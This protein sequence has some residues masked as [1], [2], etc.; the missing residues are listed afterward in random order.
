M[1]R[2]TARYAVAPARYRLRT[3]LRPVLTS[4]MA[5]AHGC[6][7]LGSDSGSSQSS[8]LS[9][10]P[11]FDLPL[12]D[13]IPFEGP[14]SPEELLS[15]IDLL[16]PE[17]PLSLKDPF[18]LEGSLPLEGLGLG[19]DKKTTA[20]TISEETMSTLRS[21]RAS[22]QSRW[23]SRIIFGWVSIS[24]LAEVASSTYLWTSLGFS[25]SKE[26]LSSGSMSPEKFQPTGWHEEYS[27][28][29]PDVIVGGTRSN[30][31]NT[32]NAAKATTLRVIR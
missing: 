1:P 27:F 13:P 28:P 32:A 22:W 26:S 31:K 30:Q 10:L 16:S 3:V 24:Y 4:G 7:G 8:S 25:T 18:S 23:M 9:A 14:P 17:D 2:L 6:S 11:L 12:D 29:P 15:P 5:Q 21:R 19:T 20:K